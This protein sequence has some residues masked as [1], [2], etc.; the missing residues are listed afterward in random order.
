LAFNLYTNNEEVLK[1]ANIEKARNEIERVMDKKV[2]E[3]LDM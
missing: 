2:K 1:E 3:E